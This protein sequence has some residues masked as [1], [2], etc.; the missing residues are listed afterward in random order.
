VLV[1]VAV[2]GSGFGGL[3]A[4]IRLRQ[5]G[6]DDLVI[7]ERANDLGG[8]WRD[9]T[10]PGCRCDVASNLYSF[11]F[12]PNPQWS[13]TYSY[14]NE[15]WQY[16][17]GVADQYHL[18]ELI[19]YDHNV[20]DVSFDSSSRRWTV[21]TSRGDYEAKCV[22][23]ATG[24][25]AEPR[26]PDIPGVGNFKGRVM[27]TAQWD[28]SVSLEGKRVAVIGTG[29]SA[30]Q[31]VPQI[32]PVVGSLELFQRTPSW[33]LPH[34]GRPVIGRSKRIFRTLPISQR[35][36]R[37]WGYWRR[38]LMVLGF[39][40]DP[41]RMTK[42][43]TM[44]REH[45]ERQ[46]KDESLREKL[47]PHYRLGCKRVLI[48]NDFYPSLTRENVTLVTDGIESID[49]DG[50]RTSDG[51]LHPADVIV[52]ATGFYVSDNPMA[53][54]VHGAHG[55][56]LSDA[57]RGQLDNYKGTTFP[58]FPNFF[59]LG[60][61]NTGL[62]HTSV[63]FMLESQLNYVAKAVKVAL[64]DDVLIEPKQ[65]MAAKWSREVQAKLPGTVW[66]SGCSS[67]YLNA[68]GQNTTIW[69]DFTFKYRQSTRHFDARDHRITTPETSDVS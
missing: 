39:V 28:H 16:L 19:K 35:A 56:P 44:S 3:G 60:G 42:A 34:L 43:E 61:P 41:T 12:A 8:T 69:P 63:I 29:A 62:G 7:L 25:L 49:A 26:L 47:T 65:H 10:Y 5:S 45:L 11:S 68:D 15:I 51:E 46:I 1:D 6:V 40:K 55:Q 37:A 31:A 30:I 23:L 22:I 53:E 27:H 48:S 13:N 32:A 21:T 14:Q 59:M 33:V 50:I 20:S 36:V 2:V 18:H 17:Q 4:A 57:F 9:N 58:D 67:W 38:E 54:K 66:G 64:S 52:A 24:G